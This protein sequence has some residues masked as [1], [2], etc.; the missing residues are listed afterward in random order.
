MIPSTKPSL[1][2]I[3]FLL[4]LTLSCATEKT[5]PP[6]RYTAAVPEGMILIEAE[7][8]RLVGSRIID[9]PRAS[10][11][12]AV[13][14][15]TTRAF[16]SY[17]LE[18]DPGRYVAVARVKA[19]DADHDMVYLSSLQSLVGFDTGGVFN[20][21]RY[22]NKILE[23]TLERTVKD[24]IQFAAFSSLNPKGEAGL[25]VDYLIICE[26]S[27]WEAEPLDLD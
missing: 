22:G 26:K 15:E 13:T 17:E 21:Y 19:P 4:F 5:Q 25:T 12:Q 27:R 1:V 23:F 18:L 20:R 9:D 6:Q 3:V 16:C 14:M 24:Y 10:G 2:P 11:G 7:A 8:F